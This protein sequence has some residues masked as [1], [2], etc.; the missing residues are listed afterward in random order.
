MLAALTRILDLDAQVVILGSGDLAAEG[1]LLCALAPRGRSL[2]RV[3]R[4][5][6]GARAPHRG[7]G[8]PLPDALALRAV[9]LEP[10]VQPALR[11]APHRARHRRPRRHGRELRPGD[12]RRAPASSCGTSTST[13]SSATVQWAVETYRERPG[14]LP[15]DAAARACRSTSAGTWRRS[16]TRTSTSGRSTRG[17]GS[18]RPQR[19]R[20]ERH[21]TLRW[22][23]PHLR[24][25][26][27]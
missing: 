20:A 10:D 5:Q 19:G 4:V 26:S 14:A 16:S 3:D 27:G 22:A 13:R 23:L 6:R 25:N 21:R 11:H 7:R 18:S 1:Y 24:G 8:R 15:R 2:P 12:R 9:R 17:A